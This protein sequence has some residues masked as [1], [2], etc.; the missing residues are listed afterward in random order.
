MQIELEVVGLA[1][2]QLEAESMRIFLR[3]KPFEQEELGSAAK[4]GAEVVFLL[5]KDQAGI[6]AGGRLLYVGESR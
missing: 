2:A 5:L 3:T 4:Q 6:E 1:L